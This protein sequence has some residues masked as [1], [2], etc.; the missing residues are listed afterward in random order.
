MQAVRISHSRG[1]YQCDLV[2][3]D[4]Q[5]AIRK[6]ST[7][8]LW[9]RNITSAAKD[10]AIFEHVR[11]KFVT[12]REECLDITERWYSGTRCIWLRK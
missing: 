7:N 4:D 5:G 12:A 3:G 2:L 10:L 8:K 1:Q 11:V 9:A 6:D